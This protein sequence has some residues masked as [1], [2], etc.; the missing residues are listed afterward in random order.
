[1]AEVGILNIQIWQLAK[2]FVLFGLS[3][4]IVFGFVVLRQVKLMND[5]LQTEYENL[6]R[7]IAFFHFLFTIAIFIFAL[8]IL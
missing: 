3:I 6:L 2:I 1:M 4:Y 7:I 8:L 5:T